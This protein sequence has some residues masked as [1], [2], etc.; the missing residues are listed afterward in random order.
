VDGGH[1]GTFG[2]AHSLVRGGSRA[3]R[4]VS[5]SLAGSTGDRPHECRTRPLV[6]PSNDSTAG[7]AALFPER[8]WTALLVS[9]TPKVTQ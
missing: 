5:P 6:D 7:P 3:P 9:P 8:G 2:Q 1:D 4:Q